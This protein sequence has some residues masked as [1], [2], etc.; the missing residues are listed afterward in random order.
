MA[1]EH[2]T[3][4]VDFVVKGPELGYQ[5]KKATRLSSARIL[6][7]IL[8]LNALCPSNSCTLT[9]RCEE[10]VPCGIFLPYHKNGTD[11]WV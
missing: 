4:F 2:A 7:K 9:E 11:G 1:S 8:S 10:I 5:D 6:L 3:I